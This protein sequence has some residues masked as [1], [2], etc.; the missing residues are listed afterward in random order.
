MGKTGCS[1]SNNMQTGVL[2][3]LR[4]HDFSTLSGPP[5]GLWN[6]QLEDTF[7]RNDRNEYKLPGNDGNFRFLP[8][9]RMHGG[10]QF[11]LSWPPSNYV[12][13]P[14]NPPL[15]PLNA[16]TGPK[17]VKPTMTLASMPVLPDFASAGVLSKSF[18]LS[19][20]GCGEQTW[21]TTEMCLEELAVLVRI[22]NHLKLKVM[23]WCFFV[24]SVKLSQLLPSS[25][26]K[27]PALRR[28][29]RCPSHP[30]V[31]PT[32]E[33]RC[34]RCFAVTLPMY[35]WIGVHHIQSTRKS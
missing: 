34:W 15:G 31:A 1:K 13:H 27:S 33:G 24:N 5:T 28:H 25:T 2:E 16:S 7:S 22:W 17:S 8:L 21:K 35:L 6:H 30:V 23:W 9:S 20:M 14:Y 12:I 4:K 19:Q 11:G 10:Q 29:P 18:R 26:P 32:S 3:S